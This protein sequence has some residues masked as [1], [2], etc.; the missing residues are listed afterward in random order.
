MKKIGKLISKKVFRHL[1]ILSPTR[2]SIWKEIIITILGPVELSRLGFWGWFYDHFR[3]SNF[4][5]TRRSLRP[6]PRNTPFSIFV[7]FFSPLP[8]FLRMPWM[9]LSYEGKTQLSLE[10][11]LSFRMQLF[12]L[13]TYLWKL[14]RLV[15]CQG[16]GVLHSE[17]G[18]AGRQL[19]LVLYVLSGRLHRLCRGRWWTWSWWLSQSRLDN[20]D[21]SLPSLYSVSYQMVCWLTTNV[22]T[23]ERVTSCT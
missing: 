12:W 6:R 23:F 10:G 5:S 18:T 9:P 8:K 21:E 16:G 15:R 7:P 22:T 2:A 19:S 1:R 20:L 11:K 17:R 4:S 14:L 3:P 13:V